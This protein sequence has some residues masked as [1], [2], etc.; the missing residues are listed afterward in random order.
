MELNDVKTG[1]ASIQVID[2]LGR[3]VIDQRL[4]IAQRKEQITLN[5][6]NRVAG[7][8]NVRVTTEDGVKLTKIVLDK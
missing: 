7:V 6:A 4:N 3:V 2:M 8:Y 1:A 5:L